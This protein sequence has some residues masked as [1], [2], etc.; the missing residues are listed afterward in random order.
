MNYWEEKLRQKS[1]LESHQKKKYVGIHL[2][3]ELKTYI[4]KT[5]RHK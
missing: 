4:Q 1:H 3:K 2:T 5:V